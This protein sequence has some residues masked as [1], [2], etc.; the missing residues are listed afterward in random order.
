MISQYGYPAIIRTAE[1]TSG[2]SFCAYGVLDAILASVGWFDV[3]R[4]SNRKKLGDFLGF[5]S[6]SIDEVVR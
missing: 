1:S 6:N 2:K 4:I 3:R 5:A